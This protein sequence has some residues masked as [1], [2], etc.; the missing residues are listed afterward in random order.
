VIKAILELTA[1]GLVRLLASTWRLE[2]CGDVHVQ[3]LRAAGVPVVFT[4]WHA[5]LLLPLWHRRG[6][7]I[8]LL[9][10]DHSDASYLA[11]A[12]IRWGYR[13]VRGSSNR[14]AVKGFLGIV[15]T[16]ESGGDVAMTPD[17][18]TGP[19]RIPKPGAVAVAARARAAIVPIGGGASSAWRLGSWDSFAIPRP[20]AR[21]R[22]VYGEPLRVE[23]QADF[24]ETRLVS[25]L[26]ERL[27]SAT[28]FATW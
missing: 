3:R 8:T 19:P 5:F 11:R 24:E 17:G 2:V 26:G 12:A 28:E 18:P 4:V 10:S 27:D 7:G 14:G 22:V 13:V 20:F 21:V 15:R 25:L 1:S 16:L 23:T 9:V 6:E